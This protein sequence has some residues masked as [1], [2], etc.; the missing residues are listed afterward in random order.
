M[1][2]L[3][4]PA[5]GVLDPDISSAASERATRGA[6]GRRWTSCGRCELELESSRESRRPLERPSSYI[7]PSHPSFLYV[8]INRIVEVRADSG[9]GGLGLG[10]RLDLVWLVGVRRF[11]RQRGRPQAG[12]RGV[13][14]SGRSGPSSIEADLQ[15]RSCQT[16]LPGS[17]AFRSPSL[18][19]PLPTDQAHRLH[20]RPFSRW[21]LRSKIRAQA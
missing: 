13:V 9:R 8:C 20:R 3:D 5:V 14:S 16:H 15:G 2:W 17:P 4:G 18:P 1:T 7:S 11:V 6:A 21:I 10:R 12:S 19:S